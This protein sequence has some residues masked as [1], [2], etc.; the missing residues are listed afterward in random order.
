MILVSISDALS[1][2]INRYHENVHNNHLYRLIILK[3]SICIL[4]VLT[5]IQGEVD[6]VNRIKMNQ[7]MHNN[8]IKRIYFK[9]LFHVKTI[10]LIY[11]P[12]TSFNKEM[13]LY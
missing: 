10:A 9:K 5:M 7:L 1:N 2:G 4:R 6:Y 11:I 13:L 8:W 12:S 3:E